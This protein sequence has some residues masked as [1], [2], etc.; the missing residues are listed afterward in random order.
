MKMFMVPVPVP[1][2]IPLPMNMYSRHTPVPLVMT[3]PVCPITLHI[4]YLKIDF[5]KSFQQKI[6][7]TLYFFPQVPVPIVVPPQTKDMK[8]AGLQSEIFVAVKEMQENESVSSAGEGLKK[9]DA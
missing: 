1:V 4:L 8:D 7:F 2:F 9:S 5:L 6:E 3:M